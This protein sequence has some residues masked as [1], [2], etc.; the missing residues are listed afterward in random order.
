M[1][2]CSTPIYLPTVSSKVPIFEEFEETPLS[3]A[4]KGLDIFFIETECTVQ[5]EIEIIL[6]DSTYFNHY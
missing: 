6:Q 4:Y 5:N 2:M 1:S 3:L